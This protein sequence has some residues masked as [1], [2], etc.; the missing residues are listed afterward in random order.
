MAVYGQH[1]G[2]KALVPLTWLFSAMA[3]LLGCA[4]ETIPKS[5]TLVIQGASVFDSRGGAWQ[6]DATLVIEGERITRLGDAASTPA[7]TGARVIDGT[8]TW[9][10][11]G[12]IDVHVHN[13]SEDYLRT[14]LAWG[15]TAIHIMPNW[16]PGGPSEMEQTSEAAAVRSPRLQVSQMFTGDFPD[17]VTPGV[18]AFL[19][20]QN[21]N[22]ARAAVRMMHGNGYRQIKIIQ[23]DST[24]MAGPANRSP[25]LEPPVFD[26]L[27]S[28]A[29]AL[30]MRVYVHVLTRADA[31]QAVAAEADA[32][33]HGVVETS[34]EAEDWQQMLAANTVW[35]PTY[36][37]FHF[38]GEQRAYAQ[39]VLGDTRL[40]AWMSDEEL[41]G[42]Q[43]L[44]AAADPIIPP[45][46]STL[47]ENAPRYIETLALN[48]QAAQAAGVAIAVGTDGGPAGVSMHLEIEALQDNGLT[49]TQALTAATLGGAVAM[50]REDEVGSLEVG[51]FADLVILNADP[52]VDVRNCREIAWVLKGGTAY[53]PRELSTP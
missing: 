49:A 40:S 12:F 50:G 19:K 47:V 28:Q 39:R 18:Y 3:L 43:T 33:M 15:V 48:T 16:P 24:T 1:V 36:H 37:A 41:A 34:L 8:G 26:A 42:F 38:F 45:P 44:A 7:P 9:V 17:N 51:K 21:A 25:R 31:R 4:P 10:V 27:V 53:T 22:Q 20:P 23:D 30:G 5:N 46:T 11:P 2:C 6:E 52:S 13:A 32:L 29:R 35:T 14:M